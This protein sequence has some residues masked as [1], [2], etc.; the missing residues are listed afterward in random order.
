[1]FVFVYLG[2]EIGGD[3]AGM[4]IHKAKP[5]VFKHIKPP[6]MCICKKKKKKKS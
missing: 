2:E 1:M 5:F 6:W 3:L 4:E